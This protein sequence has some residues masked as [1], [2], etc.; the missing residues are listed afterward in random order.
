LVLQYSFGIVCGGL[1][2]KKLPYTK[3]NSA[4]ERETVREGEELGRIDTTIASET[5]WDALYN[6]N[7]APGIV[8]RR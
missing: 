2:P 1:K 4:N 7:F 3:E 8:A 5:V 6:L